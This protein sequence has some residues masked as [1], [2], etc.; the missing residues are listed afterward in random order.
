MSTV[1]ILSVDGGGIRGLIPAVVLKAL[2]EK[3]GKLS[4][5]FHMISGTSTGGI[6]AA[7]L[8]LGRDDLNAASLVDLYENKGKDIFPSSWLS[9]VEGV[10][11]DKYSPASLESLLK[12]D[13][14]DAWLSDVTDTEL[15]VTSYDIIRRRPEFFKSW[16]AR[17]DT[18]SRR[19]PSTDVLAEDFRLRDVCRATSA[20]PTYFPPAQITNRKNTGTPE[21]SFTL[22]DGGMVA[23]NP[24]MCALAS[25]RKLFPEADNFFVLSLGTGQLTQPIDLSRHILGGAL[26]WGI[27]TIIDLALGGPSDAVDYQLRQELA[28]KN[29][30]RFQT[31]LQGASDAM[32]DASE[33]NIANLKARTQDLLDRNRAAFDAVVSTLKTPRD[34][35]SVRNPVPANDRVPELA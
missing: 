6:I 15:L 19:D 30:H 8:A 32:D 10:V 35:L 4:S 12:E 23:N 20:A 14:G 18:D 21:D 29:Y 27:T 5:A 7:A 25:A 22:I 13:F 16:R 34:P 3:V 9:P 17:R 31:S 1:R 26:G 11:S 24:A 28:T 33:A 2:E